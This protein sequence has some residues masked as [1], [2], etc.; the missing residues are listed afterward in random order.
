MFGTGLAAIADTFHSAWISTIV[1]A[2]LLFSETNSSLLP[3]NKYLILC[4]IWS[5]KDDLRRIRPGNLQEIFYRL[6][7]DSAHSERAVRPLASLYLHTPKPHGENQLEKQFTVATSLF[8]RQA[9]NPY[10]HAC[11]QGTRLRYRAKEPLASPRRC[12]GV[13]MYVHEHGE[14]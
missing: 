8:S 4:W 2:T 3:I 5:R 1:R 14:I 10:I 12:P 11:W 9:A 6:C 13:D 7:Y